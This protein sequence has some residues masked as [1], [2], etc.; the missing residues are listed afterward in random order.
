MSGASGIIC[1]LAL[2]ARIKMLDSMVLEQFHPS[3]WMDIAA[4]LID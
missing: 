4:A 1:T 3:L 2:F